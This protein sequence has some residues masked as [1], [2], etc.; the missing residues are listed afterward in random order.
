[1]RTVS[2]HHFFPTRNTANGSIPAQSATPS[3]NT[4]TGVMSQRKTR[5][6]C[7]CVCIEQHR[8]G[9]QYNDR[10]ND[11]NSHR[12]GPAG[13]GGGQKSTFGLSGGFLA[14]TLLSST[15]YKVTGPCGAARGL[16]DN[17]SGV[18][19]LGCF[20]FGTDKGKRRTTHESGKKLG[21]PCAVMGACKAEACA[22]QAC[23]K[24][25]GYDEGRCVAAVNELYACCRRFYR[26]QRGGSS[27]CCP[28][29]EVVER[30]VGGGRAAGTGAVGGGATGGHVVRWAQDT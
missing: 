2:S 9:T 18:V 5:K 16:C 12:H 28:G 22:I 21:W 24:R 11:N 25:H 3:K 19:L 14:R 20:G 17:L 1:M 27:S 26:G 4:H 23:L 30:R 8:G 15:R 10:N 13:H 6:R 29:A 7:C